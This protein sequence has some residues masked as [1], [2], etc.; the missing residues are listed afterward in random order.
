MSA[1]PGEGQAG[2]CRGSACA[3]PK[4]RQDRPSRRPVAML[5]RLAPLMLWPASM[6]R[7]PVLMLLSPAT[8]LCRRA[9]FML[10]PV[11]RMC[12]RLSTMLIAVFLIY[13]RVDKENSYQH[14]I[15]R[16]QH[17]SRCPQ[18][19]VSGALLVSISDQQVRPSPTAR[20]WPRTSSAWPRSAAPGAAGRGRRGRRRGRGR[21]GRW[22]C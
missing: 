1:N 20:P 10:S 22:R 14:R 19:G 21:G 17:R 6:L 13:R 7:L 4:S 9:A 12:S 11:S 8:R 2:S 15:N 18:R 3:S 16:A 5:W